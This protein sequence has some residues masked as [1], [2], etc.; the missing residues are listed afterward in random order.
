M[1]ETQMLIQKDAEQEAVETL[2]AF[3]QAPRPTQR[4]VLAFILGVQF[5]QDAQDQKG[6]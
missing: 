5:A 3:M 6:A 1:S 4:E 2:Q